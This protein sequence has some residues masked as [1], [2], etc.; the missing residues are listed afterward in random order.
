M[1]PALI[2]LSI[3]VALT[4]LLS[5]C[6]LKVSRHPVIAS[7]L[8]V[9]SSL[10]AISNSISTPG[11]LTLEKIHAFTMESTR[12]DQ[13]VVHD[14]TSGQPAFVEGYFYALTHPEKGL[15]LIDAGLPRNYQDMTGSIVVNFLLPMD[16]LTF[17]TFTDD[18]LAQNNITPA[19]VLLT[20]LHFDHMLGVAATPIDTPVY[21]GPGDGDQEDLLSLFG[22][23]TEAAL[24]GRP[25]MRELRFSK[26]ENSTD[27]PTL[28]V[29]GDGSLWALHLSSHSPGSTAYLANT[30]DGPQLITGDAV[31]LNGEWHEGLIPSYALEEEIPAVKRDREFLKALVTA[32]PHIEVHLG[33]QPFAK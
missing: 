9:P 14:E 5:D 10:E 29:F 13:L 28:D 17:H 7:D 12:G 1:K 11:K 25:P 15:Y 20:H 8:G 30:V 26:P 24:K 16:S 6:S 4:L 27:V 21:V 31:R 23:A 2:F 3:L 19:G 32:H 33:H 18:W 22:S